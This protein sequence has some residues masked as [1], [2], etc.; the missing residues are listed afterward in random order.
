[1]HDAQAKLQLDIYMQF[2]GKHIGYSPFHIRICRTPECEEDDP[3]DA[4]NLR[5]AYL[6]TRYAIT[7]RV[8]QAK[9]D[10]HLHKTLAIVLIAVMATY[11]EI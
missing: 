11:Q 1:M 6:R 5:H 3:N 2:Y 10:V 4:R 9:S 7:S 8:V